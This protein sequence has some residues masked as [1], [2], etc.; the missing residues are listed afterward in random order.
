MVAHSGAPVRADRLR[1]LNAPRPVSVHADARGWPLAVRLPGGRRPLP[2]R[3]EAS[4]EGHA[5]AAAPRGGP[6]ISPGAPFVPVVE[7]VDRWR[8]DDEWW[9]KEISR[10]YFRVVLAG[11]RM[12][13]VFRDLLTGEWFLQTTAT[14]RRG[15]EL[16]DVLVPRV[17]AGAPAAAPREP[18]EAS[19]GT[20][21]RRVR[22]LSGDALTLARSQGERERQAEPVRRAAAG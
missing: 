13:T 8:I 14:P 1:P 21:A 22:V 17:P 19:P 6:P 16:L 11:G 7:V 2:S 15:A 9:R 5:A 18:G 12:V 3:G 4:G 10:L 20:G